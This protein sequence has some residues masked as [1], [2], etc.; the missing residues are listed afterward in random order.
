MKSDSTAQTNESDSFRRF[1]ELT[2]LVIQ[3]PKSE[4]SKPQK[5]RVHKRTRNKKHE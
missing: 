5:A 3:V 2:R 4:I 1:R